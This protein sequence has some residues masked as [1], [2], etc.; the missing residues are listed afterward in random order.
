MESRHTLSK[1][2]ENKLIED[3][4]LD[5]KKIFEKLISKNETPT[6]EEFA[7][8]VAAWP[9]FD[10]LT[11]KLAQQAPKLKEIGNAIYVVKSDGTKSLWDPSNK[12][13][14]G[15]EIYRE[16]FLF[17]CKVKEF[18]EKIG[19]DY[20]AITSSKA[21]AKAIG[22][23]FV[24]YLA[25]PYEGDVHDSSKFTNVT[26]M[27]FDHLKHLKKFDRKAISV[28]VFNEFLKNKNSS[29]AVSEENKTSQILPPA[30]LNE[31]EPT[32]DSFFI[33]LH[34]V[35]VARLQTEVNRLEKK[36]MDLQKTSTANKIQVI[37]N[38]IEELNEAI[39]SFKKSY[40]D[41]QKMGLSIE[42][43]N[44]I[45]NDCRNLLV[46]TVKENLIDNSS[47]PIV[48]TYFQ[49][50][51]RIILNALL[52]LTIVGPII[53]KAVESNPNPT[54][55]GPIKYK[56]SFFYRMSNQSEKLSRNIDERLQKISIT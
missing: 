15:E 31:I 32:H 33:Q 2:E 49:K 46:K 10:A 41:Q 23:T 12:N 11:K 44:D 39:E 3:T 17:S 5:R 26:S 1:I 52:A 8:L 42:F 4:W 37:M 34:Q 40:Q 51:R 36:Q 43:L 28:K 35:S 25:N 53:K 20:K 7:E 29:V 16:S 14:L 56:P 13:S 50:F 48:R 38:T 55:P 54:H 24:N 27:Y 45:K 9:Q 19:A 30:P 18:F 47:H 22:I 6:P 21:F